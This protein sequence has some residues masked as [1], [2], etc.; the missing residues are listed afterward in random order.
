MDLVNKQ[1]KVSVVIVAYNAE[2]TVLRTLNALADQTYRDFE[3]VFVNNGATDSTGDILEKF[4]LDHPD[5]AI[6]LVLVEINRGLQPGRMAGLA[7]V[8]GEYVLFNDADD[9]MTPDC[10]ELLVAETDE[11]DVD[12]VMGAFQEIDEHGK[13]LRTVNFVENQC[14]W[15]VVN[16][17]A[18]LF[19]RDIIQD[20]QLVFHEG[21]LDDIDFNSFYNEFSK[22]VAYVTKPVYYYYVNQNST[23]GAKNKN[24]KWTGVSIFQET[25]DLLKPLHDRM[26]KEE[27]RMAIEY[28]IIKQYYFYLLHNYRYS[29]WKEIRDAFQEAQVYLKEAFPHYLTKPSDAYISSLGDRPNGKK[30]VKFLRKSERIHARNYLL[31]LYL[32]ASKCMYLHS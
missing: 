24:K 28:L 32:L 12:K 16:L 25:I 17:Q 29:S 2:K 19:R 5:L 27:D 7:A 3:I 21:N 9:W 18:V 23:S 22:K 30:L 6:K 11:P 1:P 14:R 13:I 15:L 31:L 20:H 8:T 26:P 4:K 10:L